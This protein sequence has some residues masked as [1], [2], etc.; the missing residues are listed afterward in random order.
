MLTVL[1]EIMDKLLPFYSSA[2]LLLAAFISIFFLLSERKGI[3]IF[4]I[5]LTA[6]SVLAALIF[7][8]YSF[9][10]SGSFS[11][12]LFSFEKIQVVE[13]SVI[14]FSAVNI[15]LL[16]SIYNFRRQ[17]FAKILV[18]FQI[19]VFII[20]VFILSNNFIMLFCCLTFSIMGV[21]Q[22]ITL[23]AG[24]S[25]IKTESEYI[26][27]NQIIRFFLVASFSL[28]IVFAGFSLI[29]GASDFKTFFQIAQ[30]DNMENPM[31][32]SGLFIIFAGTFVY[33]FIFPL[34]SAYIKLVRKIEG[35]SVLIIWFLYY[36][37]GI[38]LFL[39]M[40]NLFSYFTGKN[41]FLPA[42]L[43]FIAFICILG[44][45]LGAVRTSS[46]RRIMSFLF[47][48]TH[49]FSILSLGYL[50]TGIFDVGKTSWI[51]ITNTV[52]LN[53]IYFP[54][55]SIFNEIERNRGSDSI[56]NIKG[57]IRNNKYPGILILAAL[58]SFT[59][60]IGTLGY[61]FRIVF[62]QPFMSIFQNG[63]FNSSGNNFMV[64]NYTGGFLAIA[65]WCFLAANMVRII[66]CMFRSP[67]GAEK[68]R[69]PKFYYVYQL[70]F[71][72]VLIYTGIAVLLELYGSKIILTP[73]P[74]F[75]FS[76]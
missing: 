43:Y 48:A 13:I 18:I 58:L 28:I 4:L 47:L 9:L 41:I 71:C 26:V 20:T 50:S 65:G 5:L 55:Y 44:G 52:F 25:S 39:K 34:Q 59:G 66:I 75:T 11:D 63:T 12:F 36:P 16:I 7:N 74:V 64:L 27:K 45:N 61:P 70:F 57:F 69:V 15:L 46:L 3:K 51:I 42:A 1:N 56:K 8:I 60:L 73:V 37:V 68:I 24:R 38:V 17:N 2:C 67:D 19:T 23:L 22:L 30:S 40:I 21:F 14:L 76:F 54:V 33:L 49:G 6:C 72:L 35:T 31:L 62:I 29:Y 32:K 10:K 53:L